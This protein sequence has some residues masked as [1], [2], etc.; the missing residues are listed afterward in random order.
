MSLWIIMSSVITTI[1]YTDN[2]VKEV[3]AVGHDHPYITVY[4]VCV[5]VE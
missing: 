4:H 2:Y 3:I 1:K 5:Y